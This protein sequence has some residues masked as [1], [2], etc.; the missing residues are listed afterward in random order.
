MPVSLLSVAAVV[1]IRNVISKYILPEFGK[2]GLSGFA[3]PSLI[4][5]QRNPQKECMYYS[6]DNVGIVLEA[7]IFSWAMFT[8]VCQLQDV[9]IFRKK[10]HHKNHPHILTSDW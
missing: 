5:N 4:L 9:V 8:C 3:S 10:K 1:D 7:F 2:F 6:C